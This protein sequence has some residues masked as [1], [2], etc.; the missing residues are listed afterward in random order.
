MIC[1]TKIAFLSLILVSVLVSC[2]GQFKLYSVGGS[3]TGLNGTLTLQNNGA[4]DLAITV[5]G[6]FTFATKVADGDAYAVTVKQGPTTQ[7]CAV[8]NGTGTILGADMTNVLVNCTNKAWHRPANLT[9]RLSVQGT[10]VENPQ[11][12]MNDAGDAVVVWWQFGD[13]S[14]Q[15]YKAEYR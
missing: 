4:D 15:I 3:V 11:V 10:N 2:C 13:N 1:G 8:S 12:A 14:T 5:D 6:S 7:N 9:D